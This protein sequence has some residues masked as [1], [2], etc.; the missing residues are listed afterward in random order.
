MKINT[1]IQSQ[2]KKDYFY[3]EGFCDIDAD[4]FINKIKEGI[5]KEG[6]WSFR[7]NV[8]GGMTD[9]TYF[10]NDQKFWE[11]MWPMLNEVEKRLELRNFKINEVWGLEEAY[12]GRTKEHE[13]IPSVCSGVIYLNDVNQTLHFP[14]IKKEVVPAKGKFVI[15]DGILRHYA[16]RNLTQTPKYALAFNGD[17]IKDF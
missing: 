7:T 13:H 1:F 5:H 9:W 16:N 3:L 11:V 12:S 17:P 4:Y 10:L 2:V 6:N 14:E 15:F 8:H